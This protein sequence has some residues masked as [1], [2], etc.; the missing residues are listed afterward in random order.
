MGLNEFTLLVGMVLVGLIFFLGA[1]EFINYTSV[2]TSN[3]G[4]KGTAERIASILERISG[5]S[6]Y[7]SYGIEIA[8]SNFKVEKG[9]M[10]FEQRGAKYILP[11]PKE[12]KDTELIDVAELYFVRDEAGDIIVL[13]EVPECNMDLVC[14]PEECLELCED[15]VGPEQICIG[16]AF[17]NPGIRESCENS[18]DCSCSQ[19][20]SSY[21]CC[22]SD[23]LANEFGCVDIDRQNLSE[24]EM[25]FCEGECAQVLACN[26]TFHTFSGYAFACCTPDK[27]WNGT[28]C[29]VP[30]CS[31][32]CTP[33]CILPDT[34]DWTKVRGVNWLP[35]VRDQRNCGS[36][37]AFSAAGAV[38]GRYNLE[39][40]TPGANTNLAEQDLVS[41][42]VPL[43]S[44]MG[45]GGCEG[46]WPY[47][48]L[49]YI[50][51]KGIVYESCFPYVASDVSCSLCSDY[52]NQLWDINGYSRVQENID[53]IKRALICEGPLSIC[54]RS[55]AHAVV[56]SGYTKD[57]WII[58]NSWGPITGTYLGI[59]HV[60]G[61]GYVSFYDIQLV[62]YAQNVNSP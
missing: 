18:I 33:G 58:R 60:N 55:L 22:A 26:P 9:Y 8:L 17:C 30:E 59:Y 19:L 40:N 25:C 45:G 10:T 27:E 48:A 62:Y 61:Y 6:S 52:K 2:E 29:I 31:Y 44:L 46:A 56:L 49:D 14:S 38:E 36:C 20:N 28:D 32:P 43:G 12:V 53:S 41:C 1:Q 15:C 57:G 16:D 42:G 5:E 39:Q 50:K 21:L 3:Y 7:T 34:W 11:V 4:V 47:L 54:L 23:P 51:N 35:P 24:G 37:W 13:G